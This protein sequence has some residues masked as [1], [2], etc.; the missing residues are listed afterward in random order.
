MSLNTTARAWI[1]RRLPTAPPVAE[2]HDARTQCA[3][4]GEPVVGAF[5][6]RCG[7]ETK[8][9]L[10]TAR[11][12]L[13]EAAGRYVAW[14][15]RTWRT[16]AAL[17]FRPGFLTR[18][19]FAG[20]RR[21]YVRPGRLF[22]VMSL[23][24]FAVVRLT[25][26]TKDVLVPDP[27]SEPAASIHHDVTES[28]HT[29]FSVDEN[30]NVSLG[31]G[32]AAWLAPLRERLARFNKLPREDKSEQVW[33][34]MLRYGPYALVALLPLFAGLMQ[35]VYAGRAGRY[36]G[37]PRRYAAHLVFSAHNHAFVCL[38][39]MVHELAHFA[40]LEGIVSAWIGVYFIRSMKTVYGG[41]WSGVLLRALVVGGVYLVLFSVAI[42]A[43]ALAAIALR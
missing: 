23:A 35:L 11:A 24:F 7:Q 25:G 32:G 21:R 14:D 22:V 26:G 8:L 9:T 6:P 42:V 30:L 36:P 43:L 1:M 40:T 15:G 37:R 41:R 31:D 2:V 19:Y 13:R 4:C 27:Q 34:G 5:C 20:R 3:N 28:A 39:L 29:G 38:A 17:F 10:P 12:F 18:E 16:V 33:A